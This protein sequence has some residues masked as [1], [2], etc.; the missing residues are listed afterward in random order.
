MNAIFTRTGLRLR[1]LAALTAT[2]AASSQAFAA[3]VITPT[4]TANFNAN[5]GANALAA[6]A[7]WIA[8]ANTF[9]ANFNDNIHV[10]ITVDAVAGTS[11]FGQ[12]STFLNSF[13]YATM[14]AAVVADASSADDFTGIGGGGSVAVADPI[15]GG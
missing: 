3:M 15:T 10:N 9:S 11:V 2:L 13:S 7:A 12:S 5:F 14:R 6:Q 1:H 4:F 8:A